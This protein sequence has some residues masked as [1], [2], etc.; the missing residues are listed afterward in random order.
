MKLRLTDEGRRLA[1]ESLAKW[2]SVL[3]LAHW[4]I[5]LR[6]VPEEQLTKQECV[7]CQGAVRFD[8][9]R[10]VASITLPETIE[11]DDGE[12]ALGVPAIIIHELAHIIVGPVESIVDGLIGRLSTDDRR[13]FGNL[14]HECHEALLD[15][16]V[17][18]LTGQRAVQMWSG[19]DVPLGWEA[20]EE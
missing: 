13:M 9:Q 17:V 4:D 6:I 10:R 16:I 5:Q 2:Q 14:F 19:G 7:A 18:A 12:S 11:I 1:Q 15:T 20:V 3:L 8:E